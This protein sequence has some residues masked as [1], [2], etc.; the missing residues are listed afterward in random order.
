MDQ[1]TKPLSKRHFMR[2]RA[3]F[4]LIELAVVLVIVGIIVSVVATVLPSL[5]QSAKI[6][7][8]QAILEKIDYAV[9]GYTLAN[10]R[11][12]FADSDGDGKENAG[13]YLG[14]VPYLTLGL[15]SADDAWGNKI[16]YG[17][18]DTLT[19]TFSDA[20]AF[21]A[22][23]SSAATAGFDASKVYTTSADHLG[24]AGP[25]NSS[26]Q[27]YVISS[28]GHKDLDGSN[29][30]FDLG[31]GENTAGN[32]GFNAP[33]RIQST[34]Y[35]DL[36][37]ALSLNELNQK[38]CTGSGGS[39]GGGGPSGVE[40]TNALCSDGIDNDGDGFIDCYDQDCCSAG[41]TVCPQ[42]PPA[43]NVRINSSPMPS[44]TLGQSYTHTFL[45]TGGSGYY[46][47]YLDGITPN[48][49]GLTIS[50]WNGTLSGTI[51]NCA[52]NYTVNVRV[53][54]RYDAPKT[55]THAFTLSVA[56]G[57]LTISPSPNGGGA[58]N[59]DFTLD[60]STFAQVFTVNGGH[61]GDFNWTINW[62]GGDPGGFQITG[63]SATE[64][65]L[66]KS[67]ASTA[68]NFTFTLTAT[69]ATCPTHTFT[70]NSYSITITSAGAGAPYSANL[71]AEWR[72]DECS[73]NNTPGEVLD[74]GDKALDGTAV[75]NATTLGS[76]R[77]CRAG[78]FDGS[79]DYVKVDSTNDLKL[80]ASFSI[81][82]WVKVYQNA[83][84]WVRLVGKGNSSNRNY[85][86]WLATNG[87]VLFQ[88][89][90]AAGYGNAQ[91]SVAVNDGRWH[92]VVGVYDQSTMKVYLDNV[93]SASIS[94]SHVPLTS[95]DPFTIG[96]AGFHAYL[97]GLIDEVMLF[98]KAL[99]A[100]S[101]TETSVKTIY[102][103]TRPTCSGTCYTQPVAVYAMDEPSWTADQADDVKDSSGNG[104]H[105]TPR[106]SA[107]VNASDSHL[108][109]AGQFSNGN[110]AVEITNL[111]ELSTASGDQ[112]TVT[113]W[114]K[115]SGGD[116]EMP[117]GWTSY[118]LWFYNDLFGFN[119]AGGDIFG[120]SGA[121]AKLA[122]SWHHLAAIFTN[123]G[124]SRNS[125]FI[126]GVEQ[127]L[128]TVR[129]S[130]HNNRTVGADFRI[131]GWPNNAGYRFNGLLDEVRV[132]NRGLAENE[133]KTDMATTHACP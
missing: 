113:F 71:V 60:G 52:G 88:I 47:W 70:T 69:D 61:V 33:N 48:I 19:A 17:V 59:P 57:S 110:S 30:F 115:W 91:T 124:T 11:L 35:D 21:C 34:S 105:G 133:I 126:D 51:D 63:Q 101:A 112:T 116:S 16:K 119:T 106:G 117:L 77:V 72:L 90:S 14:D 66:S 95:D 108:C 129:G 67:A 8:A 62:Q 3:G 13:I 37:R 103:L 2:S 79:G 132:Y 49:T 7:K 5:I 36:S 1:F 121:A 25:S 78:V 4:T 50:L 97:N 29:G 94:F 80:T 128:S 92:H 10:H 6:R 84:D 100:D 130:G 83:P 39:G 123:G 55:D 76:G 12:P 43:A 56:N 125:L 114:M 74:S 15:S 81:A 9:E 26:N 82:A 46:Y 42:C 53:E 102:E 24:G 32:P 68:G 127:P 109:K 65:K 20:S 54:D 87:T 98:N 99:P 38:N 31:N 131:S 73:W 28:G 122:N 96:Y 23:I 107:A 89:Y 120:I 85:G 40:N 22:A 45:A 27:A 41:V 58:G 86:L 64:G 118:D 93:E 111:D 75:G 44:G 104:N 18:Y